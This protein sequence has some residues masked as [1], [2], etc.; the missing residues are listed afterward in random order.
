[1]T[2][3]THPTNR[4]TGATGSEF[5]IKH[6]P[7]KLLGSAVAR[8]TQPFAVFYFSMGMAGNKRTQ[9]IVRWS[10]LLFAAATIWAILAWRHQPASFGY[11]SA[12]VTVGLV[13][14]VLVVADFWKDFSPLISMLWYMVFVSAPMFIGAFLYSD[15]E[16]KMNYRYMSV[17]VASILGLI[18]VFRG[19]LTRPATGDAEQIVAREPRE[20]VSL[21]HS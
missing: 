6:D 15:F 19:R 9:F 10:P 16:N 18:V 2:L 5:R 20:H 1:L 7:A 14:G 13:C 8:S 21:H 17:V 12:C 11:F 3:T 4:W